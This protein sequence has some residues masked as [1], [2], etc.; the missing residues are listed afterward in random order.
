VYDCTAKNRLQVADSHWS[1]RTTGAAKRLGPGP[2][3]LAVG[4]AAPTVEAGEPVAAL[5]A[6]LARGA[7][8][9]REAGA[10]GIVAGLVLRPEREDELEDDIEQVAVVVWQ[11]T[12]RLREAGVSRHS[13]TVALGSPRLRPGEYRFSGVPKMLLSL[14][15]LFLLA[16]GTPA[17]E[18]QAAPPRVSV[19]VLR[20]GT[21]Y[22]LAKPYEIKGSQA[23]FTLK[24]G[25]LVAVRASDIDEEASKRATDAANAPPPPAPTPTPETLASATGARTVVIE[26]VAPEPRAVAPPVERPTPYPTVNVWAFAA[27][28]P[29]EP[30]ESP[31]PTATPTPKPAGF[32]ESIPVP[33]WIAAM[34]GILGIGVLSVLSGMSAR[35]ATSTLSTLP[36]ESPRPAAS[37]SASRTVAPARPKLTVAG[38]AGVVF[39][40]LIF[41]L[42]AF[43]GWNILWMGI[44]G[45]FMALGMASKKKAPVK[46]CP[47]CRMEVPVEATVCGHCQ[48]DIPA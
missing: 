14:A 7:E 46:L 19:V 21:R 45:I 9:V 44:G 15:A 5:L 23:R 20:D 3:L 16:S 2:S 27:P 25:T 35:K 28:T 42:G 10:G 22:T 39:G 33:F 8:V 30:P 12:L 11:G 43:S 13:R 34:G 41:T 6:G 17:A 40:F 47:S 38:G 26:Q 4:L 36:E 32:F 37:P 29:T 24:T 1:Q 31:A 18:P 48:R